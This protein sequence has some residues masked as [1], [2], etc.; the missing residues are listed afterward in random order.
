MK[1]YS[2]EARLGEGDLPYKVGNNAGMVSVM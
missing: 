2:P 1:R